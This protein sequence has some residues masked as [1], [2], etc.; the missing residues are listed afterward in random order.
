MS[1]GQQFKG[2]QGGTALDTN[3]ISAAD[4]SVN[5]RSGNPNDEQLRIDYGSIAEVD[6]E[7][8]RVRIDRLIR[9]QK[10]ER[11]GKTENNKDGAWIPILQSLHIIHTFY[12]SL[13]PGL[14]VRIF[15]R[16]KNT[17]GTEAIV[18]VISE[19][20]I[21]EFMTGSEKP[22]SNELYTGP[23]KYSQGGVVST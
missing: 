15:W 14:T 10:S 2:V 12:G 11:I 21:T 4:K 16:G 22:R 3:P 9:G 13:R 7:T 20:S 19:K 5:L 23:G 17:P 6:Y 1:I 18:E 8:S